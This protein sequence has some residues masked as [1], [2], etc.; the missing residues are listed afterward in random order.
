MIFT[1]EGNLSAEQYTRNKKNFLNLLGNNIRLTERD[2]V[3]SL[4]SEF[5]N[6]GYE[7]NKYCKCINY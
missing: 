2:F 4:Y 7:K 3:Q 5:Y 1:D 6:R